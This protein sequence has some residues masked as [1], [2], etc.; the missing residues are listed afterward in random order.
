MNHNDAAA[1]GDNCTIV[2]RVEFYLQ[3]PRTVTLATAT[4]STV[5]ACLIV[6]LS[7]S[8]K[9]GRN[10]QPSPFEVEEMRPG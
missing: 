8:T 1:C 3:P 5:L 2:G 7:S 10:F 6:L 4:R 9:A